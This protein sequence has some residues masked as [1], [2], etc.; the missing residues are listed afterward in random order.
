MDPKFFR[1]HSDLIKEAEEGTVTIQLTL[2][3][4][5]Y[6]SLTNIESRAKSLDVTGIISHIIREYEAAT[7][8]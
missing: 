4:G 1:K 6:E 8:L 3:D 7:G 2:S 5:D